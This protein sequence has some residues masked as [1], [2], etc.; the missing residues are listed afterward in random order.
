M[1]N[2]KIGDKVILVDAKNCYTA[3]LNKS[4]TVSKIINNSY[5]GFTTIALEEIGSYD[6]ESIYLDSRR[7]KFDIKLVRKKKLKEIF[8]NAKL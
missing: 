2:F 7:F 5:N 3:E 4:Y 8:K 6:N 1:S